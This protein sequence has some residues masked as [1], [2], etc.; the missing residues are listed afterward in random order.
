MPV[1]CIILST[2]N[3]ESAT[4]ARRYEIDDEQWENVS[5][6]TGQV[7]VQKRTSG[8]DDHQH[9][10]IS[11]G[12]RS[13]KIHAVVMDSVIPWYWNSP[14]DRYMMG[15][16][17][18]IVLNSSIFPAALFSL[19]KHMVHGKT[20]NILPTMMLTS[21]FRRSRI[22]LIRGTPIS[23]TTFYSFGGCA[24]LAC[25]IFPVGDFRNTLYRFVTM[26]TFF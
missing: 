23:I 7:P 6:R 20:V 26:D 5:K 8:Y 11:R 4:T 16:C 21:A 3:K 12:G 15:S 24:A 18:K 17:F 2:N 22:Q 9:I 14:A 25:I 19:T 1:S 13:T 10:G